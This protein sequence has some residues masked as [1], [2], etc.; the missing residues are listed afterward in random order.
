MLQASEL[1]KYFNRGTI[2]EVL[3][4]N[5]L[6]LN[7]EPGEFVCIIGSNGAGKS[8]LMG[9]ISGTAPPDSGKTIL[10][11]QDITMWPE[12]KRARLIG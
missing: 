1:V 8:T 12:H 2:N 7:V 9:C 4:L 3:A 6:D 11:G 5:K 10:G